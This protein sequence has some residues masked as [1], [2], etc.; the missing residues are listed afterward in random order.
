MGWDGTVFPAVPSSF[1]SAPPQQLQEN[2][3]GTL[4]L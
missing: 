1:V 4:M 3:T 2:E